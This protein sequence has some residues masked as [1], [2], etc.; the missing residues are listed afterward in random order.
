MFPLH[1]ISVPTRVEYPDKTHEVDLIVNTGSSYRAIEIK[2]AKTYSSHFT[3]GLRYWSEL[4][5]FGDMGHL[6]PLIIY[7]GETQEPGTK[8]RLVNWKDAAAESLRK[9]KSQ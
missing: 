3:Q 6:L 5:D 4:F 9:S 2:K 1:R 8:F 7:S